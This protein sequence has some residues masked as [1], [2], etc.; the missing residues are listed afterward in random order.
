M[1]GRFVFA[2]LQSDFFEVH[3]HEECSMVVPL[4]AVTHEV[5]TMAVV[6][7]SYDRTSVSGFFEDI[8]KNQYFDL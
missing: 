7:A 1:S 8:L 4:S 5:S 2:L 6:V 3:S